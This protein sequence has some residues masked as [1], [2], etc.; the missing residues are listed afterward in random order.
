MDGFCIKN[1]SFC[2]KTD[3]FCIKTDGL[4]IKNEA[5]VKLLLL[6]GCDEVVLA[7]HSMGA[8]IGCEVARRLL[9]AEGRPA[10]N[11]QPPTAPA[12]T[13][14]WFGG[15]TRGALSWRDPSQLRALCMLVRS[16]I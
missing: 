13:P 8:A 12:P 2:I 15:G 5:A 16:F 4:C 6:N 7:G 11:V 14:G 1:D 10:G 9:A 3:G